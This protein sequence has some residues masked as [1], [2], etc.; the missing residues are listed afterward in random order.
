MGKRGRGRPQATEVREMPL[1]MPIH[2]IRQMVQGLNRWERRGRRQAW[3]MRGG[4]DEFTK[5]SEILDPDS[6][7]L[8]T[9]IREMP[10][11]E[12]DKIQSLDDFLATEWEGK[13][14]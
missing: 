11:E 7:A 3:Q 12:Y 1:H 5:A 13:K 9:K 2:A 8:R 14:G 10:Q 6:K 4:S